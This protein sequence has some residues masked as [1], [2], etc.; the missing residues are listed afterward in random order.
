[1]ETKKQWYESLFENYAQKYDSENFSHG[2]VGE[3][4][5]SKKNAST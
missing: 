5:L 1:M 2:T 4:F 3:V